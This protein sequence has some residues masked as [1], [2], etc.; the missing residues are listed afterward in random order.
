MGRRDDDDDSGSEAAG[1]KGG[2]AGRAEQQARLIAWGI[3]GVIALVFLAK[4]FRV[5]DVRGDQIGFLVN[6]WSGE[7]TEVRDAGKVVFCGLWNDFHTIDNR[8]YSLDMGAEAGKDDYVK[9]KTL[10][11]NDVFVDFTIFYQMDPQKAALV[12]VENGPGDYYEKH[13][14]RDYGRAIVR[15][16]FGELTTEKFYVAEERDRKMRQAEKEMNDL[17]N[18]HGIRVTQIAVQKFS[19]RPDYEKKIAEKKLADQEV[20]Q[21]RSTRAANEET[22]ARKIQ[23]ANQEAENALTRFQGELDQKVQELKGQADRLLRESEAYAKRVTLAAEANFHKVKNEAEGLRARAEA[24]AAGVRALRDAM[25]GDGGRNLVALEYAKKLEHVKVVG[26]P[27][28]VDAE[29]QRL[30]HEAAQGGGVPSSAVA[31][32]AAKAAARAAAAKE[33]EGER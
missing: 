28:L 27:V 1:T 23:Q 7:V 12:L 2:G 17:L 6:N 3:F 19:Y 30:S 13:W 18:P 32:G 31:G 22:Q 20:E 9:L 26:R 14:V 4:T 21:Y 10:D 29:V 33:K 15:Y 5:E 24:E 8:N 16:V 25:A 11:G